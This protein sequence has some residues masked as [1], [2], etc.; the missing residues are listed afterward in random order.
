MA[1]NYMIGTLLECTLIINLPIQYCCQFQ[2]GAVCVLSCGHYFLFYTG[3]QQNF[4]LKKRHSWGIMKTEFSK[5][6]IL[7]LTV[8]L[9]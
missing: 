3:S 1:A 8:V 5:P 7:E 4:R 2:L 9:V 6:F